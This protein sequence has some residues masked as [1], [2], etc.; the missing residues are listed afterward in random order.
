MIMYKTQLQMNKFDSNIH[1][2]DNFKFIERKGFQQT[3]L[4]IEKI[5]SS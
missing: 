2:F 3:S 5:L 4:K 1:T